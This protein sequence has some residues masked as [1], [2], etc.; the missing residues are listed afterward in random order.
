[1]SRISPFPSTP[2]R[3][4]SPAPMEAG[5]TRPL[6]IGRRPTTPSNSAHTGPSRPQRSELRARQISEH[7]VSSADTRDSRDRYDSIETESSIP[8]RTPTRNQKAGSSSRS[9]LKT[10]MPSEAKEEESPKTPQLSSVL[11]AFKKAGERKRAMT[12]GSVDTEWEQERE[13]EMLAEQNRQKRI[14]DRVPGR[15]MNG[16]A[17][18]GDIDGMFTLPVSLAFF[19]CILKA[20]HFLLAYCLPRYSRS[21]PNQRRMGICHLRRRMAHKHSRDMIMI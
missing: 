16:K 19:N 5:D 7:S 6:Q 18:A 8:R 10:S 14:K 13:R 15:R 21:R 3:T 12:N 11:F 9:A 4:R 1:M 20:H 2:A 17:K